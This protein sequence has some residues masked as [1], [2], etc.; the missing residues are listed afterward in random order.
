MEKQKRVSKILSSGQTGVDRAALDAALSLG[1][2]CG[3]LCPKGRRAEDAPI[4]AHYPLQETTS[5]DYRVRTEKNVLDSDGTL[6]L[7]HGPVTG[8]TA[9]TVKMARKH[10]KPYFIADLALPAD[11]EPVMA[12]L[13]QNQ[14]QTLNVA[15][16]REGKNPGASNSR[17]LI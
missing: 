13:M 10:K 14:I 15:G 1:I 8:G 5:A 17:L 16:S 7:T 2:P 12:W 4:P 6:I 9:Y 3:G 11:I